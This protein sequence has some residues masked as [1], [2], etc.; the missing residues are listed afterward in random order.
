MISKNRNII[1]IEQRTNN[2]SN[3]E[4]NETKFV[5]KNEIQCKMLF[6]IVNLLLSC[7]VFTPLVIVHWASIWDL[8]YLY[9]FPNDF[10]LSLLTTFVAS[11][12]ILLF[13][14]LF[15]DELNIYHEKLNNSGRYYGKNFYMRCFYTYILTIAYVCSWKTYWDFYT[16]FTQDINWIY[17]LYISFLVLFF[18]LIVLRRSIDNFTKTVPFYLV[19]DNSFDEYFSQ[20]KAFFFNNV[21]L[22]YSFLKI[23]LN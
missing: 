2:S 20:S 12:S 19:K 16:H 15:Q 21:I 18:Y 7:F 13:S 14:H 11:N 3:D 9:I 6:F 23:I 8:I 1:S 17:F 4:D 10:Y 22:F 5:Q